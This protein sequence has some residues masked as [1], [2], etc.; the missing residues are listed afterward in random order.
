MHGTKSG[1]WDVLTQG[2]CSGQDSTR[3]A[4]DKKLLVIDDQAGIC[5]VIARVAASLEL[6]TRMIQDPL[7]ATEA[8]ID[9]APDVVILDMIMP[10]KD[11]IDLLHEMLPIGLPAKFILMSGYGVSY[12]RLARAVAAFHDVEQPA[13][14]TKPFRRDALMGLLRATLS[15]RLP[16][17]VP[18]R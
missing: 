4:F 15:N 7:R 14:L 12:M 16:T 1:E 8:F 10:E 11:G 2:N 18:R 3:R 13:V 9:F 6:N 5:A 17:S